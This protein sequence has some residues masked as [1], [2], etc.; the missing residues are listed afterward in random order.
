MFNFHDLQSFRAQVEHEI[1]KFL[2]FRI[3]IYYDFKL[4]SNKSKSVTVRKNITIDI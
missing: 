4:I 2:S 3:V 1:V